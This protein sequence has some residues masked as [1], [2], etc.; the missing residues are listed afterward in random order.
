MAENAENLAKL[1]VLTEDYLKA[2]ELYKKAAEENKS[3]SKTLRLSKRVALFY[4]AIQRL[5]QSEPGVIRLKSSQVPSEVM[6]R[7]AKL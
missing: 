6:A 3:R 2:C 4:N 5:V 7:Y 1:V